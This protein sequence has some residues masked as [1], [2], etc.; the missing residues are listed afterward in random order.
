MQGRL[1]DRAR[2]G[3]MLDAIAEIESYLANADLD[4]FL[5]NSMMRFASI[6]QLEIIGEA[7]DHIAPET[8]LQFSEIE[9]NQVK[10]MRNILAHE[11]FGVDSILV[12]EIIQI[13]LPDLKRNLQAILDSI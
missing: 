11:Y 8:K 9:W 2:L 7:S 1:G 6:K 4:I 3:H 5:S 13:D 10:G 12:W